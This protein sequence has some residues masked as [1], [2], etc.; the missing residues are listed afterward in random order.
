M[1]SQGGNRKFAFVL[2]ILGH[3]AIVAALTFSLPLAAPRQLAGPTVVPIETV[4]IDQSAVEAEM[5]RLEAEER[6]RVRREQ[7]AAEQARREQEE[8]QARIEAEQRELERV[9]REIEAAEQ[10]AREEAIRLQAQAR[11]EEARRA[12]EE[13]ERQK[14]EAA[15]A[16]QRRQ[17]ELAR[18]REEEERLQREAEEAERRRQEE[19]ARQREE[20][21]QQRRIAAIEAQIAEAAAAEEARRRAE[22]AGLRDQ[23]AR[24]IENKIRQ[25]WNRPPSASQGLDCVVIV[26][27]ILTG[28]VTAVRVESCNGDAAV[29]RSIEN[30]VLEASPLPPPPVASVFER[31][32]RVRFKPDE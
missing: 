16:E 30:A 1:A 12:R 3:A 18:Q 10:A 8:R 9:Q 21:E 23:W 27:Q 13:E 11:E 17:E 19:L 31:V 32:I 15:E 2:S 25:H 22:N 5:A 14:R 20:A 24:A 7:E 28:D 29:V 4:V 26:D 6:E